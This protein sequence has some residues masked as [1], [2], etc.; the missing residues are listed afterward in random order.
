MGEPLHI[1]DTLAD[2]LDEMGEEWSKYQHCHYCGVRLLT[3]LGVDVGSEFVVWDEVLDDEQG[4][5]VVTDVESERR[6]RR[7]LERRLPHRDHRTPRARGGPDAHWNLVW[8]CAECN[9]RKH[10]KPYLQFLWDPAPPRVR[11]GDLG[12]LITR[13]LRGWRDIQNELGRARRAPTGG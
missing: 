13:W 7:T 4:L 5:V 2:S 12:P 11:V 10:T 9:L 1:A 3:R 8:A 6:L